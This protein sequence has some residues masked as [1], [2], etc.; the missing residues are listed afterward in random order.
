MPLLLA[1]TRYHSRELYR[2]LVLAYVHLPSGRRLWATTAASGAVHAL[3][4]MSRSLQSSALT[5]VSAENRR[6]MN[7]LACEPERERTLVLPAACTRPAMSD[8]TVEDE[9][10]RDDL[11]FVMAMPRVSFPSYRVP[12]PANPGDPISRY[13]WGRLFQDRDSRKK[14]LCTSTSCA[15]RPME[16]RCPWWRHD[17]IGKGGCRLGI[18]NGT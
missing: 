5:T 17:T 16:P 6:A 3:V 8:P 14:P 13:A 7:P 11:L 15:D 18:R 2:F 4:Y 9:P 1:E 12:M 10:G